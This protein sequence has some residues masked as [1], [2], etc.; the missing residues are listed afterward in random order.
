MTK[1]NRIW[2]PPYCNPDAFLP[3]I[4]ETR[5][6]FSHSPYLFQ[7]FL[8]RALRFLQSETAEKIGFEYTPKQMLPCRWQCSDESIFGTTL[9]I[10]A[11][12][13][14]YPFDKGAIGGQ[15]KETS[16]GAAVH[17]GRI[18]VDFGGAH[19][20]YIPGRG[21]GSFGRIWRPL[22]HGYSTNCGHLMAVI[23]PFQ[24]VYDDACQTI[25]I[26]SLEDGSL[27]ISVPNEFIQPNWSSHRVKLIVDTETLTTGD[28]PY[29]VDQPHTH[30]PIGKTL[31]Y[32]NPEFIESLPE[33]EAGKYHQAQSIPIGRNLTHKYFNI[34]DND[35]DLDDHGMP[36][37]RINLYMK[38]ILSAR[39]SPPPLKAA[40][41]ST[42]LEHNKLTDAVRSPAFKDYCFASFTG[43][44]LDLFYEPTNNYVNLFQPLGITIKP[45]GSTDYTE[46]LSEEIF[47]IFD[48]QIPVE[49]LR[50]PNTMGETA[51][52]SKILD[53][54][55]YKPGHYRIVE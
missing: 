21:G 29:D 31:F 34:F 32:L 44:F 5:T 38:Y 51:D 20:G 40:M 33:A 46:L 14:H 18:N 19:T 4:Q 35:A 3:K 8:G 43:V 15:F 6:V 52:V 10:Y 39:H 28:V 42:S 12:T 24:H 50:L 47:S 7:D 30:T 17:H 53:L 37:S 2:L 1:T 27:L 36:K 11:Y 13:G 45:A 49:P 48:K 22:Q 9:A 26:S 41:V 23:A 16:I 55:A 25:R 54:F